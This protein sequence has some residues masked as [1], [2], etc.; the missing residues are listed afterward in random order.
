MLISYDRPGISWAT[1]GAGASFVTDP[2]ALTNG[3]PADA[4]RIQWLSGAQTTA[5]AVTL[6]GTLAK[7]IPARCAALLLPNIP[8]AIPAGV[9]ITA[10]GKLSGSA[11]ALGG[12]STVSRAAL[13]PNGAAASWYAF[14]S[15]V[16]DTIIF[17]IYNDLA[18]A[19]WAT[20]GQY[21]DL[22]EVWAGKG[23]DFQAAGDLQIDNQGGLLQRQSHNNQA[24]PLAVQPFR[25]ATVNLSPM[26]ET[27][28]IGPNPA[29]DDFQTVLNAITTA[30]ACV[31]IPE[32]MNR[33]AG[34]VD[35]GTPPP[36][37]STATI[38]QQ[39]LTRTAI[40][41]VVDKPIKL[42]GLAGGKYLASSIEF[43]ESPP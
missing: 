3:R 8:T 21:V 9:K 32:Y 34:P 30:G 19:T 17:T 29:Q 5:S 38:N 16:I 43:G 33:G 35:N 15:A 36:T 4:T 23:A 2:A 25:V 28:A 40:F 31:I 42:Q 13:L 22:G 18:G 7:P 11:V 37:I 14:P 12:N 10:S 24:W 6:T 26:T 20:A 41:G 1:S 39:R 27:V